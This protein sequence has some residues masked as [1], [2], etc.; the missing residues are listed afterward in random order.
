VLL[1]KTATP[2]PKLEGTIY[3]AAEQVEAAGGR[4][5]PVVGDLRSDEDVERAVRAAAAAFGGIDFFLPDAPLPA[6]D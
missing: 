2:H 5:V 4:A 1:A 6:R 3:T